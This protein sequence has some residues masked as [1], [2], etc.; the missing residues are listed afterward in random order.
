[1][2]RQRLVRPYEHVEHEPNFKPHAAAE[3]PVAEFSG[4]VKF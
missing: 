2:L 3:G 1:M 4:F